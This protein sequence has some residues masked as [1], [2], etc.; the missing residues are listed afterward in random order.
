MGDSS[1]SHYLLLGHMVQLNWLCFWTRVSLR[2][3][4]TSNIYI[5]IYMSQFFLPSH[6]II[7]SEREFVTLR[8][9]LPSSL[10]TLHLFIET[11]TSPKDRLL[12]KSSPFLLSTFYTLVDSVIF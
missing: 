9:L 4:C 7:D 8:T 11:V 5:Y 10:H 1:S 12:G 3:L 6:F 2:L